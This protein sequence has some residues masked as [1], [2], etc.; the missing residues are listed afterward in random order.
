MSEQLLFNILVFP[1][2]I[3]MVIGGMF[4][5]WFDRKITAWVQFRKGPPLLQPF[6]DFIKLMSKETILPR[7]ASRVTFLTAPIFAAA[8]AAI[9]GL[10]IFLPAFGYTAGFTGD[11]IVIFYILAIPS[12]TYIIGAMASGNPLATLGAS[13]EMKLIIGYELSFLLIIAAIIMKSGFTLDMAGIIAVQQAEGAFIGSIPGVLLFI[14]LLMCIQAK[15]GMVPF[16]AAEAETEIASGFLIE[17]SGPPLAFIKMSKYLL[18]IVLPVFAVSIMLG[19]FNLAG[20]GILWTVLKILLMV[21]LATLIRNTNP[22]VTIKHAMKFFFV[23]MNLLVIVAII[24]H[25]VGL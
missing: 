7:N 15:L 24:L 21:L 23:W 22:R 18:L 19:G 12:L 5:S 3:F 20:W 4:L 1:G 17:Y 25:Y 6:Y 11:I 8:G 13:R 16:D 2:L 14:A 9:A 10:M